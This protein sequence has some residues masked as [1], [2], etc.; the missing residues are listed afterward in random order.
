MLF[1]SLKPHFSKA[2]CILVSHI[3]SYVAVTFGALLLKGSLLSFGDLVK[4]MKISCFFPRISIKKKHEVDKSKERPTTT[5]SC[6]PKSNFMNRNRLPS[7]NSF[8]KYS[9]TA[10]YTDH[11]YFGG[12]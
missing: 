7:R 10:F 11:L 4:D 1:I 9:R 5:A 8:P 6:P 2:Y 12:I 3:L